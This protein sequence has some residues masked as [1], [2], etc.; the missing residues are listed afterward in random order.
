MSNPWHDV[1]IGDDAPEVVRAIIEISAGS[2]AKYELDKSSGLLRLDRVLY[3]SVHYPANYGFIPRT[4]GD[5]HD[6][7]DIL[8]LSQIN[9][10]PLCIV[11]AKVIGVM[12]MVDSGEGDDKILAVADDDISVNYI[13]SIDQLPPHFNV[14]LRQ[15]FEEYKKLENKTV[16]VEAFQPAALAKEIIGA[17]VESYNE[18][19]RVN[20]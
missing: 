12:R 3:S 5:D 1:S 20:A 19:F 16:L 15:F 9:I 14:E 7:L 13:E 18:A 10:E 6:P 11:R 8:V 17:A 2:R 4:L